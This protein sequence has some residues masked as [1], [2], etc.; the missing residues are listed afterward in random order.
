MVI[1]PC[2]SLHAVMMRTNGEADNIVID[3]DL[4]HNDMF[5]QW[6]RLQGQ[7]ALSI[8]VGKLRRTK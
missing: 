4:R 7:Q 8:I 5:F 6:G 1:T 2:D 3:I